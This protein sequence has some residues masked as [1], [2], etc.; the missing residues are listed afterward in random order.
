MLGFSLTLPATRVAV[1][2]LNPWLVS[3]WR[4]AGAG[5]LAA[6]YLVATRAP[7]PS[8]V[9]VRRLLLVAT[10]IV[11]GFPVLTSLALVSQKSAHSAVVIACLPMATAVLAVAR[12]HERP[13]REFWLASGLGM[14]AVLVFMWLNGNVGGA[15]EVADLYLLGAVALGAIGYVE[16][17][18]LSRE[19][20]GPQTVCWALVL[21]LP[22]TVPAA[23]FVPVGADLTGVSGSAWLGLGY[24]T[25]VSMF[26]GFFA[27]YAGM[28]RGGVARIGQIQLAQPV[29]TLAWSALLLGEHVGLVTLGASLAVL[30]CVVWTQRTRWRQD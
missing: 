23:A 26:L 28:A 4:A 3:F 30:A 17:G 22:V 12:T 2:E 11:I 10:G 21:A 8:A 20:G 5:L 19:L 29:L 1:A 16:G 15:V 13:H 6:G 7:L 18:A 27:W 24:V 25:V 9:Q 14:V